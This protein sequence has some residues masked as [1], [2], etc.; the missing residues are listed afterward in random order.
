M[1]IRA[2]KNPKVQPILKAMAGI[3]ARPGLMKE[4]LQTQARQL[5]KKEAPAPAPAAPE[6]KAPTI[7]GYT[8]LAGHT[9]DAVTAYKRKAKT[10]KPIQVKARVGRQ[11]MPVTLGKGLN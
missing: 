8:P 11:V 9:T 2:F 6:P 5:Q 10:R 7:G 1:G 4:P 3:K